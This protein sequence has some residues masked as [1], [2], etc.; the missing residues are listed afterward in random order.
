MIEFGRLYC[1][2]HYKN[3]TPSRIKDSSLIILKEIA[4]N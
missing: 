1:V 4:R 2:M 3:G